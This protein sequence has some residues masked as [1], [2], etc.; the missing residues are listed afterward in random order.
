MGL[1]ACFLTGQSLKLIGLASDNDYLR[2]LAEVGILGFL[3]FI[4][5][6]VRIILVFVSSL[7]LSKKLSGL[8]LGFVA[9]VIGGFFGTL[10]NAVFIDV[11]EASKFAIIF[12]LLLGY[13]VIIVRNRNYEE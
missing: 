10:I 2:L 8:E 3:G 12:W 9:G 1:C 5:I 7:P 6:L 11:F 4:L 13:A